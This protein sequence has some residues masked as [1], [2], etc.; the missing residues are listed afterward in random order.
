MKMD[1]STGQNFLYDQTLRAYIIQVKTKI[2]NIHYFFNDYSK[3][4]LVY[5]GLGYAD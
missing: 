1:Y 4:C 5:R 2:I 3:D